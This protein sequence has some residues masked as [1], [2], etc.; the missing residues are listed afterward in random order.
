MVQLDPRQTILHIV[1]GSNTFRE[2]RKV[3]QTKTNMAL[4][5]FVSEGMCSS[6]LTLTH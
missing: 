2:K 6:F 3:R 4:Q 1:H 5:D